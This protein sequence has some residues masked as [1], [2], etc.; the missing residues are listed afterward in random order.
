M[1]RDTW[2]VGTLL[3]GS[4][5]C[6]L[7]YQTVWLR[8]FRLI[9]G[10]STSATAAV[11]AIFM[12]GLGLGSA[13]LGRRADAQQNPLAFYAKLEFFIA[14]S[15][16]ISPLLLFGVAKIYLVLGG[17]IQLGLGL[18]TIVRL[19]LSTLILGIPTLL[20]GGTLP[21]AARAVET[22]DD[23]GR[24][25]LALLY[26]T[27]TLGAVTGTILSTFFLLETF[28]N[29]KTLLIAVLLNLLVAVAARSIA[30]RG[31]VHDEET[32]E[33]LVAPA[34]PPRVVLGASL[35]VGFAFLLMELVWYRMLAPILGG[36][37]FTFGLILA[38]ALLGIGTG[39]AAYSFWSGRRGNATA[40][41]FALTC[42]LEAAAIAMPFALGD[43]LA[44]T[45]NYL[46]SL[47]PL[48]FP[49]HVIA[50]TLITMVAVFPAAFISGIQFPLLIALLGSGRRDV[51]RQVGSA[52]A[53]NTIGAIAGSLAGGFG[54]LPLLSAPG[55]WRLVIVLL[56]AL[57]VLS[58]VYAIRE[59]SIA[60]SSFAALAA[61]L[62]IAG[63]STVGPTAVWRHGGIGAGRAPQL[64]ASNETRD[65]MSRM[66]RTVVW[67]A[68]GRESSVAL[69]DADDYGFIING[70]A[71]GS[72]RSDDGTQVMTGLI[73]AVLH[74]KP[75]AALV[76]GLGT[77]S[78]AGWL[79]AVPTMQSVDVVELEPA[80]IDVAKA[81]APVNHQ[82][83][84]NPKV[85]ISIGDAREVLVT[86]NRQYDIIFSEPSNPYRAGIAS[87]FT[88][89]FYEAAS[90]RLNRG[91][92]FLQWV[93]AY[94][95]DAQTV[96]TIY[97]TMKRVYANV[98]TWQTA[99]GDLLLVASHDAIV[100]D[101]DV[102]RQR[103]AQEPYR[104]A[105][106]YTWR[107][108]SVEGF[109]SHFV[110]D[111]ALATAFAKAEEEINTDD[112][113]P[114]EFGFARAVGSTSKFSIARLVMLAQ[115]RNAYRPALLRGAI[116]WNLVMQQRA[117]IPYINVLSP[118]PTQEERS[119]KQMAILYEKG[120][121]TA[122]G[123]EWKTYRWKPAN[124]AELAAVAETLAASTDELAI[125][126]IKVLRQ[127][128]P[129]EADA[130]MARLR[131]HQSKPVE[132]A[133]YL[134]SALVAYRTNPWPSQNLM[135]R[136]LDAVPYVVRAD[137]STG[138]ALFDALAQPYAAGQWWDAR[139]VYLVATAREAEGCGPHTVA[140][141]KA[142]EPDVPWRDWLLKLRRDCYSKSNLRD[143]DR[144]VDDY[145]EWLA[146]E[147]MAIDRGLR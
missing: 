110:A 18:A 85:H 44:L 138:P 94:E 68:D 64:S 128:Q 58:I 52:Y 72:A 112:R 57:G 47:A 66:R 108:E 78:T 39:G 132:A 9:F 30:G 145:E 3:F 79:G 48:G 40:G 32:N 80:V 75:Q 55:C 45:S 27:N 133:A 12:A 130:L 123:H 11:L 98:Q 144:A 65:W 136:T 126:Y 73:G 14:L 42:S 4:G 29:R 117:S 96:R 95:V 89:E 104:S 19:L 107:V 26:A 141:L 1:T 129:I 106:S 25:K 28:G 139:G 140:A 76:I 70:K 121:L 62:A 7:V 88:R 34:M 69:V 21:A 60:M 116:D 17:S 63:L 91:G 46:R 115:Q 51:G 74:P 71:D 142:L 24:R 93:Q 111:D 82:V 53:W 15:A 8:Q 118:A 143:Y 43:R 67:D 50:W 137:R 37:T 38:I 16:A 6:A 135:G 147:P 56:A 122:A 87:L 86:S 109:L 125:P 49:G 131:E 92:I 61:A 5:F 120:D 33:L 31:T 100:Y 105:M 114:I 54:L 119:R 77:G 81:C 84:E 124:T 13:L 2:K 20:M 99:N 36:S 35:T 103:L 10:A 41:A 22:S 97:A 101:A 102:L 134:R 146:G 83:L 113:T 127:F 23:D 90:C 59:R